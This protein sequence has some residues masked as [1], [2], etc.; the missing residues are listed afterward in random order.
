MGTKVRA[1]NFRAMSTEA[2]LAELGRRLK[3]E[4]L[5]QNITQAAL[6][7]RTGLA[8]RTIVKAEQGSVTTLSTMVSLLRGLDLLDRLEAFL[9]DPPLS[10]IQLAKLRGRERQRASSPRKG[11]EETAWAWGE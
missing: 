9:P 3:R 10:P 6:A 11:G 7:E 4:R 5:S 2:I 1:V 8:R